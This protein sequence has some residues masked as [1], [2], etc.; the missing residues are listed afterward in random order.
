MR[1]TQDCEEL[2]SKP[3]NVECS[4]RSDKR[5]K[6]VAL[7]MLTSAISSVISLGQAQTVSSFYLYKL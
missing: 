7:P 1:R 5:H 4:R 3:Q 2:E 6:V